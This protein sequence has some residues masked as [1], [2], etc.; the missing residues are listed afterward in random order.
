MKYAAILAGAMLLGAGGAAAQELDWRY[1]DSVAP[2]NWLAA[3]PQY[4]I[5]DQGRMQSP[6][7][8]GLANA[9]GWVK[10]AT[11]YGPTQGTLKL[12]QHKVQVDAAQGQGMISGDTLFNLVQVHFHTP[13]EHVIDGTR[14][15]LTAHLVHTTTEGAL[16][17]L[18]VMF[19]QGEPNAGLQSIIDGMS[20]GS[21]ASIIMDL[22][23][24]VPGEVEVYRYQG[25]LTTPPC[26]ENV[27]WHV[28]KQPLTAS[29]QQ[30]AAFEQALSFSARSLQPVNNRLVVAPGG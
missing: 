16:G 22:A 27:N 28:V 11:S 10:I 12:G 5:C 6:I 29:T 23:A 14:Y 20:G 21:N 15:P 18:G 30:I 13:S 3:N 7:D 4:A 26:S 1:T 2:E 17:V 19:E 9:I 8:L 25:S 24:L